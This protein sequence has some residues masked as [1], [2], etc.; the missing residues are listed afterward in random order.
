MTTRS[1]PTDLLLATLRQDAASVVDG[2]QAH[3]WHAVAAVAARHGML[4][5]LRHRLQERGVAPLAPAAVRR[6]L[7]AAHTLGTLRA[8]AWRRQLCELLAALQARE[9]PVILLKGA[10]LATHAYPAAALRPMG[11]LDLLVRADMLER[12]MDAIADAGYTRP[13][14]DDWAAYRDHRHPPPLTRPGRLPVELHVTIE[15]CAPPFV[16]PL[17]DLW[18]RAHSAPT[19]GLPALALS[20]EDLL[21]HLATHMG[22]SHLL[23]ASLARVYDLAVWTERFGDVADWDAVVRRAIESGTQRFVSTALGLTQRLLGAAVPAEVRRA[24]RHAS[25]DTAIADAMALL[26]ATSVELWGAMSLTRPGV[27]AWARLRRV[28]RA[29]VVPPVKDAAPGDAA[30]DELA[31]RARRDAYHAR[32]QAVAHALRH[33]RTVRTAIQRIAQVRRLRTWATGGG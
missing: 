32:W 7:D 21:L 22:R 16:L 10:F 5:L 8:E 23:G 26:E 3:E 30:A 9:V 11:D 15:P 19:C 2:L 12:S 28:G 17:D 13:D 31:F 27:S 33:P 24:L 25:D 6:Q 18:A 4:P 29:L 20:P 14:A 1:T